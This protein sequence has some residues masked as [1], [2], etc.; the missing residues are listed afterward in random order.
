MKPVT[1]NAFL[2]ANSAF[3]ALLLP[4]GVG[5]TSINQRPGYGD[6]RPWNEPG[7]SIAT[8]TASP[9][10][11]TI[12]RMGNNWLSWSAPVDVVS[13]FD[14]DDTTERIYFTGSG[15]PKWT[16]NIIGL[17]GGAPFPQSSRE[18]GVPAPTGALTAVLNTAGSGGDDIAYTWAYT[19]V[20]DLGWESAPSPPSNTLLNKSGSTFDL[21][22]FTTPPAGNYGIN[23][24]R[25]YRFV[26]GDGVAGAYFF[27][28]EFAIGATP[29][30]PIDD[31]RAVGADPIATSGWRP[32]PGI[33][34][35]GAQNLT[36]ATAFGLTKLWNGMHAL[37]TGKSM[38]ICEPFKP[39]AWPLAYEIAL[40]VEPVAIGVWG[41]RAIILTK[42]DP[43]LV[44]GTTPESMDDE[45]A[46]INRPCSSARSVVEFNEGEAYKGV[47]WASEEGLCWYGDGG[48]RLLTKNILTRTQWQA[49]NPATMVASRFEGFYVCFYTQGTRKGF[50][51]DPQSPQ[52]IYYLGTG[53][54]A[55]YR[56]PI[57]DK[58]YILNG[59]EIRE[60]DAGSAMTATFRS[61]LI[62][63]PNPHNIG[64]I[65]VI[66]KGYPV[67]VKMWSDGVLRLEQNAASD[68]PLR[69]SGGWEATELQFEVSSASTVIA[70]RASLSVDDLRFA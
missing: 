66:A 54:N 27:L 58:L 21:S 36:E 51:I 31:A 11:Q 62:R 32:A 41:Q 44:A 30:N 46:T 6:L 9:Q 68:M 52:G 50:V 18:L 8:V 63:M 43:V 5:V 40:A 1:I 34:G 20:N 7:A 56:D 42:G 53:Y 61:K 12:Y 49:M 38:R 25:V 2:G 35:G 14:P 10:Q 70:L 23:R 19:Y 33:P 15:T 64:A 17:A 59:P 47:A 22:G 29:T 16:N 48:F 28:R 39:Y 4:D 55:L 57:L 24:I 65:E 69:P 37:L 45:P 60:W 67:A 3:D 26:T 13:G